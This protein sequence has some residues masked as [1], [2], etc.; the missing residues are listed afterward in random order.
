VALGSALAERPTEW[1][2]LACRD[3][4]TNYFRARHVLNKPD[5]RQVATK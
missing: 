2:A 5:R 3:D 4:R 1:S